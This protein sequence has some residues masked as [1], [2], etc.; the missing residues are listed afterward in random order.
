MPIAKEALVCY[1]R[2]MNNPK[3]YGVVYRIKC[4][5]NGKCY[6]GQTV[7]T[8]VRWTSHFRKDS[9]CHALRNAIQKYGRSNFEFE[10]VASASSKEELDT[11]E[12]NLVATSMSPRGYNLKEG[13][14][15][16][17]HTLAWRKH[18]SEVQKRIQN[19]PDVKARNSAGVKRAMARPEV[20]EKLRA[21]LKARM[22]RPEVREHMSRVMKEVHARPEQKE[23]R[24]AALKARWASYTTEERAVRNAKQLAAVRTPEYRE[25]RSKIAKETLARP[26]VKKKLIASIKASFTAERKERLSEQLKVV[27]NK[28]GEREKRGSAIKRAYSTM[29]KETRECRRLAIQVA[30][31]R[32]SQQISEQ[33]KANLANPE[34]RSR[35]EAGIKKS[36]TPERKAKVSSIMKKIWA[37]PGEKER[38]AKASSAS[39]K[40]A[41]AKPGERERRRHA[42]I[43]AKRR[44]RLGTKKEKNPYDPDN[45]LAN[46]YGFVPCPKCGSAFRCAFNN[47]PGVVQCD[48]CGFEEPCTPEEDQEE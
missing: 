7:N 35:W 45:P 2:W 32:N 24:S 4:L 41:W 29:P 46:M 18:M 10:I 33:I 28:P 16:G 22:N 6:H 40:A 13:G 27:W 31:K 36:W 42:M 21:S 34:I 15:H 14:A 48:E 20:K 11:I 3:P 39:N 1:C 47:K 5:V 25:R 9:H 43:G 26:E 37:R 19:L 30:Q 17:K 44:K 38:R 23:K 12:K 8:K